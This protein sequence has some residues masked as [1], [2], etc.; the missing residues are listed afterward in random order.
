MAATKPKKT[1]SKLK[2]G[3]KKKINKWLIIGGVAVVTVI[4][5]LVVRFSSASSYP[6]VRYISQMS[7]TYWNQTPAT[8]TYNGTKYASTYI[9]KTSS[10]KQYHS[11]KTLASQQEMSR[12]S[13]V[14]AHVAN[15]TGGN[16]SFILIQITAAGN[17]SSKKGNITLGN[18]QT[19]NV[20]A[21]KAL[22]T[23]MSISVGT[24]TTSKRAGVNTIYGKF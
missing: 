10:G 20:C 24:E 11:V 23:G 17:I 2:A 7:S 5:A 15:D 21:D 18:K 1:S 22:N 4:G 12:S 13:K 6:F 8:F 19:G 14:C 9:V 16:V 3:N